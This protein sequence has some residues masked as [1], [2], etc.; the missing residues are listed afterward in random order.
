MLP[1]FKQRGK[2]PRLPGAN[3]TRYYK[4]EGVSQ[5][6]KVWRN[7]KTYRRFRPSVSIPPIN[8]R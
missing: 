3:K 8:R 7:L 5:N 6:G 2:M 4:Q 1:I